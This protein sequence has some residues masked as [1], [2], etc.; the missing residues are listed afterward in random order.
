M[1]R[2]WEKYIGWNTNLLKMNDSME[3]IC[4][5][6]IICWLIKKLELAKWLSIEHLKWIHFN[7]YSRNSVVIDSLCNFSISHGPFILWLFVV[8][9]LERRK[10]DCI[11]FARNKLHDLYENINCVA[12][13]SMKY[14]NNLN[15]LNAV[16][17]CPVIRS[18]LHK[19]FIYFSR[20]FASL[21]TR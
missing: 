19:L 7:L 16:K 14:Y 2:E 12:S 3:R 4:D 6:W 10:K 9:K 5:K 1:H 8:F 15:D 18:T 20:H 21:M 13:E 17:H 11:M